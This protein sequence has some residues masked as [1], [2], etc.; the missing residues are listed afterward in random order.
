MITHFSMFWTTLLLLR[1]ADLMS[2]LMDIDSF[3]LC[4]DFMYARQ[5]IAHRFRTSCPEWLS[6]VTS[7]PRSDP[8]SMDMYEETEDLPYPF[9]LLLREI[10]V[11][12][13]HKYQ[14]K[15]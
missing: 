14:T 10:A 1:I 5:Q 8:A 15:P 2:E 3:Y 7:L 6:E 9:L 13:A 11:F 12:V 4:A